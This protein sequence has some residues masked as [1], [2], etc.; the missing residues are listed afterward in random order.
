M[1][2]QKLRLFVK[3]IITASV[4]FA[5]IV[6]SIALWH[7]YMHS[8]WTRDGRVRANVIN[9][10]PDISGTVVKMAVRDNQ[11]VRKGE[12]LFIIDQERYQLA[13]A[14]AEAHLKAREAERQMR[15]QEA[16][17]RAALG[18]DVV[19]HENKENAQALADAAE[20]LYQEARAAY[21]LAKLNLK[22]T[23]VR[24]PVDG[25]ITNLAVHA[26][27]FVSTGIARLA[28]IDK[29]SFWVYGYFEETKLHLFRLGDPVE[30]RLLGADTNLRGHVESLSHG[31]TDRDNPTGRELLA[32]V[33]PVFNWVRLAQRV[34]VRISIDSIPEDTP[35][36]AGMTCTLVVTP[37]QTRSMEA[38]R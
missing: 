37:A 31:I 33:N 3:V 5:A 21:D 9:V 15:R 1:N 25:Y 18:N 24:S 34:P 28:V 29:N 10:A 20:A 30:I 6:I 13:M 35:L 14:Q 8:P 23:E 7:R 12:L 2:A 16:E 22:R 4:F 19:S 32:N 11:L 27:D 38:H 17:R 26:G 36:A